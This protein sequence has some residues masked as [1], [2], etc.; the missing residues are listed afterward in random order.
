VSDNGEIV[1]FDDVKNKIAKKCRYF[2]TGYCKYSE[3]CKFIHPR[4]IC[5]DYLKTNKCQKTKC[6]E[7]HPKRCKWEETVS[8]C[9]RKGDCSYLH[10]NLTLEVNANGTANSEYICVSCNH[11]WKDQDCMV[12]HKIKNIKV[13][14]CLNCDDWVRVKTAV[15][16]QGWS[17]FDKDGF[18]RH[19]I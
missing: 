7:R 6:K 13:F 2:D 3:K 14:F 12:E 17:L 15:F 4:D 8:G 11:T 16:D 10:N 5:R 18:L 19:D 9:R 1:D